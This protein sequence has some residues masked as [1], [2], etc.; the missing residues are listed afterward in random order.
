MSEKIRFITVVFLLALCT[1][2]AVNPLTGERE[3][4]L[5]TE[6]QDLEIGQK[7]APEL[8][9]E[10]G[11]KIPDEALQNYINTVGQKVAKVSHKRN[12]E[13]HFIALDD[14]MVNAFALPG[15]YIFITKGMLQQM[16]TESQLASVLGHEVAHV[17]ARDTA[18][19]MS[20]EIGMNILLSAVTTET[21]SAT[22]RT[23][24]DI[25][26][27][28]IGLRFSRTDEKDADYAGMD[29]MVRAG[30]NPNGMV[31][32]M[33]MLQEQQKSQ[34]IEFFSTH[35]NPVNRVAYLKTRI[36]SRYR[37]LE[38]LKTGKEEFSSA[39]LSRLKPN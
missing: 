33:Q 4:M 3:L 5:M 24:G 36:N 28:I 12:W 16:T 10:M 14:D 18:V 13:Y 9:K 8:E 7:Y 35:P 27:Q 30:Y 17:V 22:V 15:G 29:Y 26:R 21:T 39:V 37:N 32:T 34:N 20:R 31:E 2:C 11:G 25:T 1:G 23:V 19:V 6:S 38:G